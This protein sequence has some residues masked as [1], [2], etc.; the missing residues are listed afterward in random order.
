MVTNTMVHSYIKYVAKG[1]YKNRRVCFPKER[2]PLRTDK[3]FL[4]QTD[5]TQVYPF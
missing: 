1:K 5:N 2:K 4:E 3:K